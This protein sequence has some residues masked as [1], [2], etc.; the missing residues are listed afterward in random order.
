MP[1]AIRA[2]SAAALELARAALTEG[3]ECCH[4]GQ[5]GHL[6]KDC[7]WLQPKEIAP[8]A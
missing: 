1:N 4:C 3:R 6:A 2:E 7:P 5:V 8:C